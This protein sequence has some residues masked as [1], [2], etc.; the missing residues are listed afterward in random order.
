MLRSLLFVPLLLAA[1]P[2]H[3][4]PAIAGPAAQDPIEEIG[5]EI[6]SWGRP[7]DRW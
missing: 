7:I 4:K 2:L 5:F 1:G 6:S 3:K